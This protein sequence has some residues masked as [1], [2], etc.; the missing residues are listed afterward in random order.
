M[1]DKWNWIPNNA[2]IYTWVCILYW[3]FV[4]YRLNAVEMLVLIL[5]GI[6]SLKGKFA[7][8]SQLRTIFIKPT[9]R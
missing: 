9:T 5:P 4:T 2:V 1:D 7:F 8:C 3:L 6:S